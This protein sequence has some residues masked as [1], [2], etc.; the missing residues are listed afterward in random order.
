[1][2]MPLLTRATSCTTPDQV[3]KSLGDQVALVVRNGRTAFAQPDTVVQVNGRD[4]KIIHEGA[5]PAAEIEEAS[6]C[7]IVFVCTGNTCRS[8]L[9]EGLCRKLLADKL[10]CCTA[11]L[12][13]HG[14]FVQSAGLAAMTGAEATPEAAAVAEE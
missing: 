4:W 2:G 3:E 13:Q 6:R 12:P 10:G 9:A 5:V 14:F 11:A 8:P 7:R 1:L